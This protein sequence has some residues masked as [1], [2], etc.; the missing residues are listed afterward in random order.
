[1][2]VVGTAVGL[3]LAA[4]NATASNLGYLLQHDAAHRLDTWPRRPP[5]T[6]RVMRTVRDP[7][8]LA[9]YGLTS[10]AGVMQVA[11]LALAPLSLV[12]AVLAGGVGVLA[13]VSHFGFERRLSGREWLGALLCCAGLLILV[14]SL[15]EGATSPDEKRTIGVTILAVLTIGAAIGLIVAARRGRL[16]SRS[17]AGGVAAGLLYGTEAI[18]VKGLV[19]HI[20]DEG[21]SVGSLLTPLFFMTLGCALGGFIVL[22]RTF[23]FGSAVTP[24]GLMTVTTFTL[25]IFAGITIFGDRLPSDP[26][27][28]VLRLTSF[29]T[30]LLGGVALA[31]AGT[32]QSRPT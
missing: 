22:Q 19:I 14:I 21:L 23:R 12:Q 17:A 13:L 8:W 16:M 5:V 29:A 24:V 27:F 20:G 10:T 30:I 15:R 6:T 11:A 28:L 7:G 32:H 4:G 9:G 3:M 18:G 31:T 2:S 1:M 26:F 25:P